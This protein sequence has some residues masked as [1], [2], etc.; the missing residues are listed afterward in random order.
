MAKIVV[1]ISAQL[2][3]ELTVN[4]TKASDII[5]GHIAYL[6]KHL[7]LSEAELALN[8]TNQQKIDWFLLNI[9]E[10]PRRNALMWE[11]LAAGET[12]RAAKEAELAERGWT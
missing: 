12:A 7:V 11:T 3:S 5:N 6:R 2:R 4:A 8:A 1:E 9:L 10:E